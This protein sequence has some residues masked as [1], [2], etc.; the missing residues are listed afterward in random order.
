MTEGSG[1][2]AFKQKVSRPGKSI[3]DYRPEQR[4]PGMTN[5]KSNNQRSQ[6]QE[7][8]SGVHGAIAGVSVL[9]Q[10][11]REEVFVA[12]K[13]LFRHVCPLS[14]GI[15][16]RL[17]DKLRRRCSKVWV[18]NSSLRNERLPKGPRSASE[19][20]DADTGNGSVFQTAPLPAS[21]N[22]AAAMRAQRLPWFFSVAC[23]LNLDC[24]PQRSSAPHARIHD[25][26][27]REV[28]A[29]QANVADMGV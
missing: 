20:L 5:S 4:I 19:S 23:L 14:R 2:V 15:L 18:L 26:C 17:A 13:L 27:L 21:K 1:L 12:G 3:G 11:E 22:G 7:S 8:A 16:L 29:A 10:I 9:M 6:S 28:R 25:A 24:V